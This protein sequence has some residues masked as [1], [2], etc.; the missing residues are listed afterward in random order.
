[1]SERVLLSLTIKVVD[2]VRNALLARMLR[3]ILSKLTQATETE[4]SRLI[5]NVG[6]PLAQRLSAIAKLWGHKSADTWADD[7]GFIQFLTANFM[8]GSRG[9]SSR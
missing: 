7:I 2:E 8:N 3:L 4:F 6:E 9:A 5:R 1:M